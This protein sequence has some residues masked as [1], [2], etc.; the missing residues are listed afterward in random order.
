MDRKKYIERRLIE[1][2]YKKYKNQADLEEQKQLEL[3]LATLN[4]KNH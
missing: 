2:F 1:L 4:K 3:E